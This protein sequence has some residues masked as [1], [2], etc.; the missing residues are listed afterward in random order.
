M[1]RKILKT[2]CIFCRSLL[3]MQPNAKMGSPTKS[4]PSDTKNTLDAK[5]TMANTNSKRKTNHLRVSQYQFVKPLINFIQKCRIRVIE[6][7]LNSV[8]FSNFE[9]ETVRPYLF[10]YFNYVNYLGS[11]RRAFGLYRINQDFKIAR[12]RFCNLP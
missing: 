8:Q 11:S 1:K 9:S 4:I 7:V 10:K 12:D 2:V 3:K 5:T 6:N